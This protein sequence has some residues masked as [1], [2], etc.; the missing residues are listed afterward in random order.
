[1]IEFVFNHPD[2]KDFALGKHSKDQIKD[3]ATRSSQ[4][5]SEVERWLGP[6]LYYSA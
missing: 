1:M 4:E 2:S 3:Y 5:Q 6:Y